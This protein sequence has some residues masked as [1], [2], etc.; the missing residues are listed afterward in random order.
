M[1]KGRLKISL[2]LFSQYVHYMKYVIPYAIIIILLF[3][4][5][6]MWKNPEIKTIET[7]KIE[8]DTITLRD[9]MRIPY[10][11]Y[12]T[13]YTHSIDTVYLPSEDTTMVL[14]HQTKIYEDSTYKAQISGYNPSLDWIETYNNTK[15][16]Y[17][18]KV[19]Q[20]EQKQPLFEFKP[21]V[22]IGYGLINNKIDIYVGG[23]LQININR[24]G[25]H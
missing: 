6:Y 14:Q 18:E 7:I 12:D 8:R 15:Y 5:F 21:S 17:E 24:N 1:I 20:I 11:V 19:V 3:T 13:V 4:C 9:T 10:P 16:I 23:S 25:K 22:G 2:L